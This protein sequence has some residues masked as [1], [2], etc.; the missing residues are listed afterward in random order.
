MKRFMMMCAIVALA[1]C[2]VHADQP[3]VPAEL[4]VGMGSYRVELHPYKSIYA[5]E[6]QV[7]TALYEGLFSYDPQTLDPVRALAG[8]F[9]KSPDGK[10]WTFRIRQNAFWSDGSPVTALDFVESW[11]YLLAPSTGAEYAVF[12]DIIKGA[13][14][15]RTGKNKRADSVGVQALDS[16]T[17][18]VELVAPAAYFTRLLCHSAFVPVHWSMRGIRDWTADKIVGNGPY[19]ILSMDSGEMV[20]EAD[21]LYWDAASVKSPGLRILFLDN[22]DEATARYN[23]GEIHW[24]MDMADTDSLVTPDAMQFS[25]MFGTSYY[26]W[27]A[28]AKPWNDARVRRALALMIPW[29]KI[30]TEENYFSPTKVLILPFAGYESPE[31]INE[32]NEEEARRLLAAARFKDGKGLPPVRFVVPEGE[33]H[34]ANAAIFEEAWAPLGIKL[35]VTTVPAGDFTRDNRPDGFSLSFNGWIGEFD[36]PAAF[37]LMW[38]SDSGLNE[39]KYRSREYDRLIARSMNEEGAT[40]LATLAEAEG[41]LLADAAVMPLYHSLSF[42]VVD[43]DVIQ[44]W[45]VN[46]LDMHPFKSIY[47]GTPKANPLI[48]KAAWR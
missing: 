42:N 30:R 38:V 25:P 16:K 28:S 34:Q 9:E 22:E 17:L 41:K 13:Q 8:S 48:V 19:R 33:L 2:T 39:A 47:V 37:L 27:N 12:L 21:P 4:V 32:S 18:Q 11:R 20:L 24:L 23:A 29:D 36:D 1:F 15:Y 40:R 5:H 6:M 44:G 45:Y 35:E 3:E 26:F 43:L 7:F 46:P 10:T 31:G 14:D